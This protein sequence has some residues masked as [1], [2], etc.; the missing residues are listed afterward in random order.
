[1]N[2][3]RFI[4]I[5]AVVKTLGR[6]KTQNKTENKI[7]LLQQFRDWASVIVKIRFKRIWAKSQVSITMLKQSYTLYYCPSK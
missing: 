5:A 6:R 3:G 2:T 1:M 4:W 7:D